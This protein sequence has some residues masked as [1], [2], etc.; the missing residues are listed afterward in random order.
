[1]Q[2]KHV[3]SVKHIEPNDSF[4]KTDQVKLPP[5]MG[6]RSGVY[7]TVIYSII[8]LG[9][10]F[11]LLVLPGLRN[12]GIQLLVK[13][14]PMGAAVRIDDIYIGVSGSYIFA[15]K[16]MHI[17]T[18]VMPGFEQE[19]VTLNIQNRVFASLFFPLRKQ[20]E[21]SLK[22]N[23]PAGVFANAAYEFAEWS[24]GGEPTATWQSPLV[25]SENAYR[26]G[27]Y[28]LSQ[29]NQTLKAASRFATTRSAVRELARAK[30]LLDN[31]GLSPIPAGLLNSISDIFAFLSENPGSANWFIN[32]PLPQEASSLIQTSNWY[33]NETTSQTTIIPD[34]EVSQSRYVLSGI[35]FINVPSG[36]MTGGF[37]SK[38]KATGTIELNNFM[39]SEAPVPRFAFETFM[40]EN[41]QWAEKYTDYEDEISIFPV[42]AYEREV[43]SGISWYAAVAFCKWLTDQLPLSMADMEVR[44]PS[45]LEWEYAAKTGISS[46]ERSGWEWCSDLFAPFQFLGSSDDVIQAVGSPERVLRGKPSYSA[47][48]TIAS[49]PPDFT[50]P[51]V[52]FRLVITKKP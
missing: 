14:E 51:F 31:G 49:L 36:K 22:T 46:M 17:I 30:I 37:A 3:P 2:K 42:E 25:L 33:K 39:I 12:P 34:S 20:I 24:F 52:T 26:T 43:I 6:I 7:I 23:D 29:A 47:E 44:L 21:F 32:L 18:A 13:T 35:S 41:P 38:S 16:G 27:P 4:V 45:G 48:Q 5:I 15:P 9:I 19:S 1:M 40:N 8:L 10:L 28:V 11:L 50:S